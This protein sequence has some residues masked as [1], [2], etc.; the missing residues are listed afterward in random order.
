MN[1]LRTL[2]KHSNWQRR[3]RRHLEQTDYK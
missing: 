1:L 2:Y 3:Q